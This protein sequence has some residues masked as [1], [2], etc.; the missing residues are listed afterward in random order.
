VLLTHRLRLVLDAAAGQKHR[1]GA[2]QHRATRRFG[3]QPAGFGGGNAVPVRRL[4]DHVATADSH[5]KLHPTHPV[6]VLGHLLQS[7][8][9]VERRGRAR[10]R[11]HDA[12][13]E[14]LDDSASPR[15]DDVAARSLEFQ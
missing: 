11:R 2:R 6:E 5:T 14:S 4:T 10:E 7:H 3:T 1:G 9:G 8:G 13:A 12:V 15:R